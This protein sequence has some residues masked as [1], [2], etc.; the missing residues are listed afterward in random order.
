MTVYVTARSPVEV[1]REVERWRQRG[2]GSFV[3]RRVDGGGFLDQ[4]RLGA[5]RYAAGIQ[6]GVELEGEGSDFGVAASR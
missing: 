3:L 5:A 1:A 2:C 6:A 4:E